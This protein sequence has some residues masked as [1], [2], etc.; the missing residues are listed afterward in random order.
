MYSFNQFVDTMPPFLQ[1][2]ARPTMML[3]S[4]DQKADLEEQL[5]TAMEA[6]QNGNRPA[7]D[8]VLAK[9][10]M[11]PSIMQSAGYDLETVI[12]QWFERASKIR[13]TEGTLN[14]C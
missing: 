1:V 5:N 8:D 14:D 10:P 3:L 7:L 13:D 6:V 4:D 12:Q 11:L 9:Y 2:I